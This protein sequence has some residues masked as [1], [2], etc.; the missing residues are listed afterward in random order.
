[1]S[2]STTSFS[3]TAEPGGA[4]PG[5]L[6]FLLVLGPLLAVLGILGSLG[7]HGDGGVLVAVGLLLSLWCIH[8]IGRWGRN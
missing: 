5:R 6:R 4:L 2:D 1:M 8:S 3:Q 7:N